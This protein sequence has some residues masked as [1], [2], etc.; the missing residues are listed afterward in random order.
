MREG[1]DM[2]RFL[3]DVKSEVDAISDFPDQCRGTGGAGTRRT[4]AVVSI[5]GHR[6]SGTKAYAEDVRPSAVA[7]PI[8]TVTIKGL[9][10]PPDPNRN[11]CG[12]LRR[13]GLSAADVAATAQRQRYQ[14]PGGSCAAIRKTYC[15]ASMTNARPPPSS[16]TWS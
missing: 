5:A 7:A 12:T 13:Y 9:L 11:R 4:D 1:A 2:T 8:A 6:T 16:R 14:Q 10:P 3:D 15:C